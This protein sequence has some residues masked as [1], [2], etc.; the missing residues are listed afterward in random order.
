MRSPA[1]ALL[2]LL[3]LLPRF[4]WQSLVAGVDVVLVYDQE[5]DRAR[6]FAGTAKGSREGSARL[7]SIP[8]VRQWWLAWSE[9]H[10]GSDLFE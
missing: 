8:A 3:A 5:A 1:A 4:L 9:Y 6:A 10:P 7:E 2:A